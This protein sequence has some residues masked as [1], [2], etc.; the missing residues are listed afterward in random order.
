MKSSEVLYIVENNRVLRDNILIRLFDKCP[1]MKIDRESK[2]QETIRFT[3]NRVEIYQTFNYGR[4][5]CV[6]RF[7]NYN[8]PVFRAVFKQAVKDAIKYLESKI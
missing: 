6:S 3:E 7:I 5:Q 2:P 1:E 4:D 8:T